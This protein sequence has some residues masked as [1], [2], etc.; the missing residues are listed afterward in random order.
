MEKNQLKIKNEKES[1]TD[2]KQKETFEEL[3]NR[4]IEKI[5]DLSKQIDL[6]NLIY[7]YRGNTAPKK[8]IGFKDL[9]RFYQN[10][11]EGYI[12]L[13]KVKEKQK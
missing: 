1:S 11:T 9:L 12:A 3:A 2:L 5:Q 6:N 8:F 13:E 4:R 7:R 10:I